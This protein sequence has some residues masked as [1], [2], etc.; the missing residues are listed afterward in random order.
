MTARGFPSVFSGI[1]G[2]SG[3]ILLQPVIREMRITAEMINLYLNSII[4]PVYY[5][6]YWLMLYPA[7]VNKKSGAALITQA[8]IW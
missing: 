5:S 1:T 2:V 7:V 8:F 4:C 3:F 6:I